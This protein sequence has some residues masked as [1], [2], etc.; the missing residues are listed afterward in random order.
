MV[1]TQ[2][3]M[4]SHLYDKP[5]AHNFCWLAASSQLYDPTFL[6]K[7]TPSGQGWGLFLFSETSLKAV[8]IFKTRLSQS[9]L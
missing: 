1:S 8:C 2:I 3:L 5:A 6:E 7:V 9:T 4:N